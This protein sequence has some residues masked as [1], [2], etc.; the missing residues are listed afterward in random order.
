[1]PCSP[2]P[3]LR[4]DSVGNSGSRGISLHWNSNLTRP[5]WIFENL[6][7]KISFP[8]FSKSSF[9]FPHNYQQ[10]EHMRLS[11]NAQFCTFCSALASQFWTRCPFRM[12]I[13]STASELPP[14]CGGD[15]RHRSADST[16]PSVPAGPTDKDDP[17]RH[18]N[19]ISLVVINRLS[20]SV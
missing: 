9:K 13:I 8:G 4:M 16:P 2:W 12:R 3:N 5:V 1:M 14:W 10:T 15:L 18:L 6:L 11:A 19:T 7:V 17:P 20:L